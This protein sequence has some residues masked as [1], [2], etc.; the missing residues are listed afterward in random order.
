[1]KKNLGKD[2]LVYIQF[3][4]FFVLVILYIVSLF[5]K[6]LEVLAYSLM[7]VLLIVMAI[8]NYRM[9]KNKILSVICGIVGILVIVMEL[10]W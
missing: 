9:K 10:L 1:M 3:I 4:L 6:E 5:I 7:G 2:L 8:N